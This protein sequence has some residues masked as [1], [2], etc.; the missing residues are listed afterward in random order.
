MPLLI[1]LLALS[2][3]AQTLPEL[4]ATLL[5]Q[6]PTLQVSQQKVEGS[7]AAEKK[8]AG[9]PSPVV[10]FAYFGESVETRTGPQLWTL[11]LSQKIPWPGRIA[12]TRDVARLQS[13]TV[14]A[15]FEITQR[16]VLK[17]FRLLWA[18]CYYLKR[19]MEVTKEIQTLT[20][21][22]LQ[23]NR[24]AYETGAISF[25]SIIKMENRLALLEDD[26]RSL[27][28]QQRQLQAQ[29]DELFGT[30]IQIQL[31][32]DLQSLK[33]VA[34]AEVLQQHPLLEQVMQKQAAQAK[35]VQVEKR[36][37]APDL[38]VGFNYINIGDRPQAGSESGK[39]AWAITASLSLP[40]WV[41]M[42]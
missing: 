16:E 20:T 31:P 36:R 19:S 1:I 30:S 34:S 15:Q 3:S 5:T 29:I 6:N 12:K 27:D 24:S 23:R 13:G 37:F 33:Y 42:T 10:K 35:A 40:L 28:N 8:G 26:L 18:D 14:Q 22:W 17:S 11:G 39:D 41:N 2:L 21:Q 38:G 4:E 32:E 25:S 9:L 7:V